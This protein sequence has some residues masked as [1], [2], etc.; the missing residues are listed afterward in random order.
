MDGLWEVLKIGG[1]AVI[2]AAAFLWYLNKRDERSSQT[3]RAISDEC[4]ACQ[5]RMVE[6][7][8]GL[9]KA[10]GRIEVIAMDKDPGKD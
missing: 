3:I 7:T 4:H 8:E 2:T 6:T 9:L 10:V 1:S 5:L